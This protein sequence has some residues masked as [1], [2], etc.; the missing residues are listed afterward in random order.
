[1][2]LDPTPSGRAA[3][4]LR[5]LSVAAIGAVALSACAQGGDDQ[6]SASD[7]DAETSGGENIVTVEDDTAPTR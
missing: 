3:R 5:L 2:T 7:A 1:M 4:S 6:A